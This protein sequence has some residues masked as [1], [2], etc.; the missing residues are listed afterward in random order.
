[1]DWKQALRHGESLNQAAAASDGRSRFAGRWAA[2]IVESPANRRS[3]YRLVAFLSMF[4]RGP[5]PSDQSIYSFK[6]FRPLF[7]L[8]FSLLFSKNRG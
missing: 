4:I 6:S 8:K 2:P 5:T 1:V 3:P 7:F